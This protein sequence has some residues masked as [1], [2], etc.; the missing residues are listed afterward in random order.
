MRRSRAGYLYLVL[1]PQVASFTK[2]SY[3]LEGGARPVNWY[4]RD[5]ISEFL[6]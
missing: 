4:I 6:L 5:I 3:T 1:D 2:G